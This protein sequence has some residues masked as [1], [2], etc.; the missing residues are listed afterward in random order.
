MREQERTRPPRL[1]EIRQWGATTDVVTAATA[2]GIGRNR[3]YELAKLGQFPVR[4]VKIGRTYRV[5][6]AE[7]LAVLM[8]QPDKD[9]NGLAQ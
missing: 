5:V 7:L 9:V 8:A 2:F 4:V 6:V 1:D 3:A